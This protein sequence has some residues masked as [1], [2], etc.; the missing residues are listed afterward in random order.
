MFSEG[1]AV[2]DVGQHVEL[3][4]V[5]QIGVEPRGFDGQSRQFRG[6]RQSLFLIGAGSGARVKGG[7]DGAQRRSRASRNG[8]FDNAQA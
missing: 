6:L 5:H 8:V 3:R 4:T 2:L 7:E 1:E